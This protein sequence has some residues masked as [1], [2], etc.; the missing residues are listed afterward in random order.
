MTVAGPSQREGRPLRGD[1]LNG[2]NKVFQ[3]AEGISGALPVVGTYIGA[4]AKVGLTVVQMLQAMDDNDETAGRLG[5]HVDRLSNVLEKFSKEPRQPE[6]SKTV[7][8]IDDLQREL[9]DLQDQIQKFQSQ[10]GMSRFWHSGDQSGSLR[11]L[12]EKIRTALE[13]IQ[14]RGPVG[15][16]IPVD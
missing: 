13:E 10:R 6:R 2:A 7:K 12:Q 9:R 4:V 16:V 11:S 5:T 15:D 8:E 14:V 1:L 3:F